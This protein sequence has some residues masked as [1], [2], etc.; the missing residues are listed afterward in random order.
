MGT[1]TDK[2]EILNGAEFLI[3]ESAVQDTFTPED[4][5]EEQKMIQETV[6]EFSKSEIFPNTAK[7]EKQEDN[8]AGTL[9]E[10]FGELGL[11]GTHMP[12]QYG[13]MDMD[14]NTNTIIGEAVGPSGS[15][16]VAYNAH[17]GIGMLPILYFGTDA[18]KEK[19]LPGL[20]TG[21]LKAS[22]CLTEPSSGSDAL[23][24]KASAIL[25]EDGKHYILNGQKM[26]ITNAGFADVF[27]VFAQVDGDKFTGFIVD[28]GLEGLSFGEEEA[29]LGIKGSSTRMVFMENLKVPVDNLL[30][31]IGKGHQI[32]FNVLNTGRFKLG[33]SVLGGSKMA[34]QVSIAYAKERQQFKTPISQF[35]AIQHKIAEMGIQNF[36]SESALYRTSHFINEKIKDLKEKGESYSGAKLKAAEEYALECSIIKVLGSEVLDYCVD[37][38]VQI[39]GGMGY[40]EEGVIARAYRDSR[41]NRIFEG[42][43]EINRLV[44]MNTVL[45]KAMKGQMDIVTPA[46]AVQSELQKQT[47]DT[48]I[49]DEPYGVQK[50]SVANFKKVLLMIL[51]S[52]AK[53]AMEGKLDLKKEQELLMNM[54]DIVIDI[55]SVESAVMRVSKIKENA[56]ERVSTEI[57]S[58]MVNIITYEASHRIYKNALDAMS[59]FVPEDMQDD[60]VAGFRL[61]TKY[62][63]Q[64]VK[65]LRR[66][67]A[68]VMIVEGDYCF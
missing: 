5:S 14:F 16:S 31:E 49:Y 23:S 51:G 62:P 10:K 4:F 41:I 26:W 58:D 18:Q 11:L 43:N 7:I 20:A 36:L 3:K 63:I 9:L 53:L 19:Y 30:G 55:F 35:G 60:F 68:G 6:H 15:F 33:S 64:D 48:R 34:T 17:T 47:T 38:G 61:F 46:L 40:S 65:K 56:K 24:A 12:E 57:Y 22:Y 21:Q 13:G 37:E 25:S 52:A 2:I 28:R 39:H 8:I 32:A 50:Q 27:T 1:I 29:K 66:S 42:T 44:I 45:K 59:S 67:I 54:A